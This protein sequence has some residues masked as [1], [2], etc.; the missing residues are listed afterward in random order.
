MQGTCQSIFSALFQEED[1][2]D[3]LEQHKVAS[4]HGERVNRLGEI[5]REGASTKCCLCL[6][7]FRTGR[8]QNG[9]RPGSFSPLNIT[10]FYLVEEMWPA[11]IIL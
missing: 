1:P 8:A 4:Y 7:C 2:S 5:W 9:F 10:P 6:L 11:S 3:G